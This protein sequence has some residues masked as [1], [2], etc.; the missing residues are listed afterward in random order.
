MLVHRIK[1]I[2]NVCIW[3]G[4]T[5]LEDG[6]V[7]RMG[8][9]YIGIRSA[10]VW[11]SNWGHR[12]LNPKRTAIS[13]QPCHYSLV[14]TFSSC[15]NFLASIGLYPSLRAVIW[16]YLK[17]RQGLKASLLN[18]NL[19][20]ACLLWQKA[21]ERAGYVIRWSGCAS[22]DVGSFCSWYPVRVWREELPSK[23]K[24][25]LKR[26][27]TPWPSSASDLYRPSDRRLSTK[28]VRTLVGRNFAW[29][30]Q[31]I[32]TPIFSVF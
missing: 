8:V 11:N 12:D 18:M 4:I 19:C 6:I 9:T 28:F 15:S 1:W 25:R 17:S 32:P 5:Y 7:V 30:A 27:K 22:L 21:V 20:A 3:C 2:T 13:L 24:I 31:R 23:V 29:S 26:N 16:Y 10:H 14:C